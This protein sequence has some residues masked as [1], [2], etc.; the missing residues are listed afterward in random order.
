MHT[1]SSI[2]RCCAVKCTRRIQYT[3]NPPKCLLVDAGCTR[4]PWSPV[5]VNSHTH[6]QLNRPP[7]SPPCRLQRRPPTSHIQSLMDNF[8]ERDRQARFKLEKVGRRSPF[9]WQAHQRLIVGT[10]G[11]LGEGAELGIGRLDQLTPIV[12]PV[13]VGFRVEFCVAVGWRGD[14]WNSGSDFVTHMSTQA[15]RRGRQ[16]T[17]L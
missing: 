8:I 17:R 15:R 5:F 12:R 7:P 2:H 10:T 1:V 9:R 16:T 14:E 13:W 6:T 3:T 11:S 4:N